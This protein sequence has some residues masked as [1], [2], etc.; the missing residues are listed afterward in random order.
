[1]TA[2]P[3]SAWQDMNQNVFRPGSRCSELKPETLLT[4]VPS[5][6]LRSASR[7]SVAL[8]VYAFYAAFEADSCDLF[9]A[10]TKSIVD[11]I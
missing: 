6:P 3:L 9:C 1:M 10:A 8:E 4:G 11:I 2:S 5:L 7:R